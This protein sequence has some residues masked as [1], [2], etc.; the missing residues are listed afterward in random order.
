MV[1][2]VDGNKSALCLR[3]K[4]RA[5]F[6]ALEKSSLWSKVHQA[7]WESGGS[8]YF[9]MTSTPLHKI[10]L[11]N[12]DRPPWSSLVTWPE[13]MPEPREL[14]GRKWTHVQ[15]VERFPNSNRSSRNVGK[16]VISMEMGLKKSNNPCLTKISLILCSFNFVTQDGSSCRLPI[17]QRGK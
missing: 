8:T 3:Y 9:S 17:L 2:V 15:N 16:V 4:P 7:K 13:K 5:R 1:H 6:P 14:G 12:L 10:R 11:K